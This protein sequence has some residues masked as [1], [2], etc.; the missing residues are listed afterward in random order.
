MIITFGAHGDS[1]L[2]KA[3]ASRRPHRR[4]IEG[5]GSLAVVRL[6]DGNRTI[7]AVQGGN[8]MRLLHGGEFVYDRL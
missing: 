7:G 2:K 1:L 4:L 6:I 5:D 3:G 8:L